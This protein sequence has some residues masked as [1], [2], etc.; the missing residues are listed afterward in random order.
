MP[1]TARARIAILAAFITLA[2]AAAYS[3]SFTDRF[4]G[5]DAKES[6][7]DNPHIR[8]LWP[9][10][11]AMSLPLLETTVADDEGSK[12]G[13]VVRRPVLSLTFALNYALLGPDPNSFHA[14]N[15]AIHLAAALVVFGL[16][17]RTL[18]RQGFAAEHAGG[19]ALAVALIW[20]VHPLQT[21]AVTYLV[22]RAESLMGLLL[23]LTLYCSV[24]ALDSAR[25]ALWYA[26]AAVAC[27][28]GMGTKETMV[29]APLLVLL[30]DHVF[31]ADG[32]CQRLRQRW[33]LYIALA[34][35]WLV[36]GVLIVTTFTDAMRDFDEGRTLPYLLSQPRVLLHYLRLAVWPHPLHLYVNTESFDVRGLADVVVPGLVVV[37]SLAA[38]AWALSRKRGYGYLAAWFFVILAP[39]SSVVATSDTI[40]EHRMYLP[41]AAVLSAIV[42]FGDT[43]LRRFCPANLRS[44]LGFAIV[45]ATVLLLGGATR[46][47]NADYHSEFSM[48]HEADLPEAYMIL[49]QHHLYPG[50][51]DEAARAAQA[52]LEGHRSADQR[53]VVFAHFISGFAAERRGDLESAAAHFGR[54]A[55]LQPGFA[56]ARRE[57][58]SVLRRLGRLAEA[59]RECKLA[60]QTRPHF[61][62]AHVEYGMVLIQQNRTSDAVEHFTRAVALQPSSAEAHYELGIAL[63]HG[64]D[65]VGARRHLQRAIELRV[66]FVE[67]QE[68]LR[69]VDLEDQGHTWP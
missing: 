32:S 9:L 55:E 60:L 31:V 64:G 52:L 40:Q 21:E 56:Y 38:T 14:V 42:V 67:A 49:A 62:E 5:L 37:A 68:R 2:G 22:Q 10:S 27:A 19:L 54:A 15:L 25:P 33:P 3:N 63:H 28:L 12:G 58:A 66:D 53:D 50:N 48:V 26:A 6:I 20:V 61:A 35:C 16:V 1:G 36:L 51:V 65:R 57:L 43:A 30:Y 41:L 23:L 46:A 18:Q 17:R 69:R 45:A 8:T 7:R 59:A 13:T 44:S 47:R 4:A 39:T 24:R 29:V 11:E 34:A